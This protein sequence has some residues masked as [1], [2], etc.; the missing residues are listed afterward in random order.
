MLRA[1]VA[2]SFGTF[3]LI[4]GSTNT[5]FS[6]GATCIPCLIG[7]CN[8][9]YRNYQLWKYTEPTE[10]K[11][12]SFKQHLLTFSMFLRF[13]SVVNDPN[14]YDEIIKRNKIYDKFY[15]MCDT[16]ITGLCWSYAIYWIL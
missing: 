16:I 15:D 5:Y 2:G 7:A 4:N 13:K 6:A 9:I 1:I 14:I 3:A 11:E 8:H 10:K 12:D